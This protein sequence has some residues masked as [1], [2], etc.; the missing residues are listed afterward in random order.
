M[1]QQSDEFVRQVL[2]VRDTSAMSFR[3]ALNYLLHSGKSGRG[4]A[5]LLGVSESTVRRWK[6]GTVPKEANQQRAFSTV[7][8]LQ[9]R[10]SA[11]GDHGVIINVVSKE[12]KRP[13]RDRAISGRQLNLAPGTLDA[14]KATWVRT[15]DTDAAYRRFLEGVR[16]PFYRR[17]LAAGY[18]RSLA[19]RGG[20]GGVGGG[21][22][23]G[24][25][26]AAAGSGPSPDEIDEY[27]EL[28]ESYGIS[29]G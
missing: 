15:G 4:A 18:R 3:D 24:G 8:Q 7:R 12:S 28:D 20:N 2:R 25:T 17:Q 10:V 29:L 5:R 27:P 23:A 21:G 6:G 13:D 14:V 22:G 11:M 1:S 16:E 19:D 9:T 26:G